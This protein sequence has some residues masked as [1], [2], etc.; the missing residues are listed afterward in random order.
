MATLKND[1]AAPQVSPYLAQLHSREEMLQHK[2]SHRIPKF[3]AAEQQKEATER[4]Q[5]H[6][7]DVQQLIR[8]AAPAAP[9]PEAIKREVL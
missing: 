4:A 8:E 9:A 5:G 2:I 7:S 3:C 1:P 6:L